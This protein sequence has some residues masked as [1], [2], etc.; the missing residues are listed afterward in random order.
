[1]NKQLTMN[2]IKLLK[3]RVNLYC[4]NCKELR[5]TTLLINTIKYLE[6]ITKNISVD[7]IQEIQML[8][9]TVNNLIK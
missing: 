7:N 3:K 6:N 4:N 2:D 9:A 5:K 1:M 8:Y